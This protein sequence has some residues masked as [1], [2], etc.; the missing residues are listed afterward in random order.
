ME[1]MKTYSNVLLVLK[2]RQSWGNC[3]PEKVKKRLIW[4]NHKSTMAIRLKSNDIENLPAEWCLMFAEQN[5]PNASFGE[6]ISSIADDRVIADAV[7]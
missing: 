3:D 4:H 5:P 6:M 7:R 2:Q 1:R